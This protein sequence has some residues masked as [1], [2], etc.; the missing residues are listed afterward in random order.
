M[1]MDR[2]FPQSVWDQIE[3]EFV[4]LKQETLPIIE[5]EKNFN[6]L[7]RYAPHLVDMDER[8]ARRFERGLR[9]KV[10]GI[11]WLRRYHA[12]IRYFE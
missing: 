12:T 5:Y 9:P 3:I 8:K 1:V 2:Y 11:D 7:L 10:G 6:Q 4:T